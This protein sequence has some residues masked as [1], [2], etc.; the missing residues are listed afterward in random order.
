MGRWETP[1]AF[2]AVVLW[3]LVFSVYACLFVFRL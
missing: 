3:Y 1:G 2:V